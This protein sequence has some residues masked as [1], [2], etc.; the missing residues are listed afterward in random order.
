M[1]AIP[2][3]ILKVVQGFT[4]S[5]ASTIVPA[6]CVRSLSSSSSSSSSSS[7][8]ESA[9][10]SLSAR[11]LSSVLP[12]TAAAIRC[13]R[14]SPAAKGAP[15]TGAI[16]SR[17]HLTVVYPQSQASNG[18]TRASSGRARDSDIL[19]VADG[20]TFRRLRPEFHVAALDLLAHSFALE[21]STSHWSH[22]HR[23]TEE[24]WREFT[25]AFLDECE[26]NCLSVVA[27]VDT[28]SHRST[29]AKAPK[30]AA[31]LL[32]RDFLAPW[33]QGFAARFESRFG[34][35][36][37]VLNSLDR[38]WYREHPETAAPVEDALP[39]VV[40]QQTSRQRGYCVDL[41]MGGVAEWLDTERAGRVIEHLVTHGEELA[42]RQ[43]YRWAVGEATGGYSQSLF[44]HMGYRPLLETNYRDFVWQG[45]RPFASS[46]RP[47][48]HK[49]VF[50]EKQLE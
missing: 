5:R 25:D 29:E 38:A 11:S 2:R 34:P 17:R 32:A 12:F 49:W 30:L 22:R 13:A 27:T 43:G 41:W 21:P 50:C 1:F 9:L 20:L 18:A 44:A 36:L 37:A 48:H 24:D 46:E 6:R 47:P 40:E 33:P 35:L 31:A 8:R 28:I 16:S 14:R 7:T 23:L 39:S 10:D 19:G 45:E 15:A 3:L 42:R 4:K 26:H